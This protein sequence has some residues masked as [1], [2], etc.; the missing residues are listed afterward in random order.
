MTAGRARALTANSHW[1]I[2]GSKAM[3][4]HPRALS[5]GGRARPFAVTGSGDA[6]VPTTVRG[7]VIATSIEE[8]CDGGRRDVRLP[9]LG[10]S[11]AAWQVEPELRREH[12]WANAV[13]CLDKTP[14]RHLG[15]VSR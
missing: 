10:L 3:P 1:A 9:C 6:S 15:G 8:A 5:L 2:E 12:R 4:G 11:P 13:S 14:G 7:S